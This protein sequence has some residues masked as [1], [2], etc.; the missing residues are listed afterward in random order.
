MAGPTARRWKVF[1]GRPQHAAALLNNEEASVC[2]CFSITNPHIICVVEPC[3]AS[4]P[5]RRYYKVMYRLA[6]EGNPWAQ[7]EYALMLK[8]QDKLKK[9]YREAF[10]NEDIEM[11]ANSGYEVR[12]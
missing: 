3:S 8:K 10:E 5:L 11:M 7:K 9:T 1:R 4:P 2:A 6:C 12:A